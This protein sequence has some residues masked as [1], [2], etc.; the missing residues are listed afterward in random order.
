MICFKDGRWLKLFYFFRH[1]S[2]QMTADLI[3]IKE[4]HTLQ[5]LRWEF[6][7]VFISQCISQKRKYCSVI[8]QNCASLIVFMP[9]FLHIVQ[10]MSTSGHLKLTQQSD[11]DHTADQV[12]STTKPWVRGCRMLPK[13]FSKLNFCVFRPCPMQ[14]TAEKKMVLLDQIHT[15]QMLRWESNILFVA[16]GHFPLCLTTFNTVWLC[17]LFFILCRPCLHLAILIFN[18]IQM[19]QWWALLPTTSEGCLKKI[20]C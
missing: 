7:Y 4:D 15:L 6:L 14:N 2:S 8:F 20:V 1:C 11:P 19:T 9:S 10:T 5:M 17:H 16:S 12:S 3:L 18:W 13:C